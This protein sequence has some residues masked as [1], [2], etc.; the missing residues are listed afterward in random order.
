LIFRTDHRA[1]DEVRECAWQRNRI[2]EI[3]RVDADFRVISE[4][5]LDGAAGSIGDWAAASVAN[6]RYG[7]YARR[8]LFPDQQE[9]IAPAVVREGERAD[10][11]RRFTQSVFNSP[12]CIAELD[13][14]LRQI[15]QRHQAL[16]E[17]C[18]IWSASIAAARSRSPAPIAP[19]RFL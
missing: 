7:L 4:L 16:D 17:L 15:A 10:L 8:R 3:D 19:V 5:Q 1:G 11:G 2:S 6:V 13:F 9:A 12:R 18:L 14:S